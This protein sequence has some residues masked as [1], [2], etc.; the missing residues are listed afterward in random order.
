MVKVTLEEVSYTYRSGRRG[1]EAVKDLNLTVNDREFMV[2]LGPSGCGKSTTLLLIA[3]VYRPM[4]GH[5]Y[6]DDRIVDDLEPK[7]RNV[8][9]VFQSYALYPH[10]TV[11]ENIA[12]PLKLKKLSKQEIDRR[13]KEAASMLRIE[14]LLDRYPR[15][16]SGGQQ[17]R[18]ALAR[19][20]AK[21]PAIFLMDE[22]LSNLDAKIRVEVRAE[23]KRLQR[24]I[25]ITTIYVTHDQAEAMSLADRI[26]VMNAGR[27]LQVGTPEELY[28]RP[29]NIF[30]AGFIG[31]PPANLVDANI[32]E[33]DGGVA[34]EMLGVRIPLP[35][36]IAAIARKESRVVFMARPEDISL[37]PG[38]EFTVY[39]V[40]WHGREVLVSIQA[41]DGTILKVILPA[42]KRIAVGD[43]VS[44]NFNF[45]HTHLYKPSGELI[46]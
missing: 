16:L 27:I 21:N 38:G 15:Q 9:M 8:G 3:G 42:D 35:E 5:I 45:K 41:P 44:I 37:T 10:M 24:E 43:R 14:D 32:V 40:E 19:A 36:D 4:K 28:H 33:I 18:V 7:D 13:V 30:V 29:T 25:G 31:S 26:A 12:F 1:V 22:P 34:L 46:L 2:L 23:L 20:I 11:Y 17:Q 6:F 39:A